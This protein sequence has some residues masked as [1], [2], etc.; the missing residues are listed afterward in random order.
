[1]A[2]Y[3]GMDSLGCTIVGAITATGGGTIRDVFL[4]NVPVFWM[5]EVEYL[6]IILAA[7]GITFCFFD[8][9]LAYPFGENGVVLY[10]TDTL[11]LGAFSVIG[12]QNGIRMGL[13]PL[14]CI[15]CGLITATFG[16][17][18]RDIICCKPVRIVYSHA[19]I[20]SLSALSGASIYV[21]LRHLGCSPAVRILGGVLSVV[22]MR[23]WAT[24]CHVMLPTAS[25]F[26]PIKRMAEQAEGGNVILMQTNITPPLPPGTGTGTAGPA[27]GS[28]HEQQK[29]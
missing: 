2:G 4:G 20:Y 9:R 23:H 8:K 6:W 18:I 16:G 19:E 26:N 13:H 3:S 27:A 29:E 7:A 1:M 22:A 21:G 25:W 15:I 5:V 14:V 11:G 17:V 10:A 24:T 28:E 12:A